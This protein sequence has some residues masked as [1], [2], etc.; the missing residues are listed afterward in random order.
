ME[1]IIAV[2]IFG[3]IGGLVYFFV[4]SKAPVAEDAIQRRLENIAVQSQ[5]R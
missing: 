1:L 2:G 4:A 5:S 3:L